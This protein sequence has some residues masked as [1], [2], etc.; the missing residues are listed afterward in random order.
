MVQVLKLASNLHPVVSHLSIR[1]QIRQACNTTLTIRCLDIHLL[2]LLRRMQI[3]V[4][5]AVLRNT[6]CPRVH[7]SRCMPCIHNKRRGCH[8][9][10]A[11]KCLWQIQFMEVHR[12]LAIQVVKVC[13][14][15]QVSYLMLVY[16]WRDLP[17]TGVR[18]PP[19]TQ[20]TPQWI[21]TKFSAIKA[22]TRWVLVSG[23]K[24][25]EHLAMVVVHHKECLTC[26]NMEATILKVSMDRAVLTSIQLERK[27]DDNKRCHRDLPRMLPKTLER[28]HISKRMAKMAFTMPVMTETPRIENLL[29]SALSNHLSQIRSDPETMTAHQIAK[30]RTMMMPIFSRTRNLTST[31]RRAWFPSSLQMWVML[32]KHKLLHHLPKE[33]KSNKLLK[34]FLYRKREFP[35]RVKKIYKH[36]TKLSSQAAPLNLQIVLLSNRRP[37]LANPPKKISLSKMRVLIKWL[38]NLLIM[39]QQMPS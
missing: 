10:L 39:R 30:M 29:N 15:N 21:P 8:Q 34:L 9:W 22:L 11:V 14:V 38:L 12:S 23:L 32:P 7:L 17:L 20:G 24:T 37:S 28:G 18:W 19:L 6:V 13:R 26:H 27:L 33:S 35:P 3:K 2:P 4:P 5:L 16:L 1:N 31:K 36:L 25:K